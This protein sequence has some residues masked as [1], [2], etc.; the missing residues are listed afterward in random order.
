LLKRSKFAK[1]VILSN[2]TTK[3]QLNLIKLCSN[4]VQNLQISLQDEP[5]LEVFE[6][7]FEKITP[8]KEEILASEENFIID[9]N[10]TR[11]VPPK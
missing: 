1:S 4:Y 8:E 5:E 7:S 3:K 9:E 2:T 10:D 11:V 6:T